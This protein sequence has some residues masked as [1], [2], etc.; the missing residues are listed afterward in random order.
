M[1]TGLDGQN[2][3]SLVFGGVEMFEQ[4]LSHFLLEL[5]LSDFIL[6]VTYFE[7][8]FLYRL[9]DMN[10]NLSLHK[11]SYLFELHLPRALP[12]STYLVFYL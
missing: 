12:L 3:I 5:S 4:E 2:N 1:L 7:L 6:F 9:Q 10:Q 8:P 11:G